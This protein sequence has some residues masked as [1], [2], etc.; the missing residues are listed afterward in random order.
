MRRATLAPSSTQDSAPPCSPWC[1]SHPAAAPNSCQFWRSRIRSQRAL[2]CMDLRR[3]R[4]DS[5]IFGVPAMPPSCVCCVLGRVF[6]LPPL[7]LPRQ[8]NSRF[9]CRHTFPTRIPASCHS[10]AAPPPYL[11]S[12]FGAPATAPIPR[13]NSN[14]DALQIPSQF[15]V[16]PPSRHQ[17][18]SCPDSNSS[19]CWPVTRRAHR[20]G[21]GVIFRFLGS[22]RAA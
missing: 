5:S 10:G 7:P 12:I 4:R 20:R 21:P 15:S 17:G 2:A 8:S 6:A 22:S 1:A 13:L 19:L 11:F 3:R 9:P 16:I 14:P 18:S